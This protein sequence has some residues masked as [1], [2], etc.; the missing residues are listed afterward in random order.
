VKNADA[1]QL[2]QI[3]QDAQKLGEKTG[4]E[5]GKLKSDLENTAKEAQQRVGAVVDETKKQVEAAIA[6]AQE[7]QQHGK[8]AADQAF[9]WAK[10]EAEKSVAQANA[11]Y[12]QCKE[13][14][15]GAQA[16]FNELKQ[17]VGAKADQAGA[18]ILE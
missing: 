17:Q 15:E 2:K 8:A 1:S 5:F 10:S 12:A 3:A 11:V 16:K 7:L 4:G 14:Y 6:K 13:A 18:P 9:A